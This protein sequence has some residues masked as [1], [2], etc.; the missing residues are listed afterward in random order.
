MN[1]IKDLFD[2]IA[3][4]FTWWV[5]VNP[6]ESGIRVTLGKNQRVIGPGVWLRLPVIHAVYRQNIRLMVASGVLML[7]PPPSFKRKQ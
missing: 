4:L 7:L 5:I 1:W 2:Y 6:W 3:K